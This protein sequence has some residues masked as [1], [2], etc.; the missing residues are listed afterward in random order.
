MKLKYIKIIKIL[1]MHFLS[2][3]QY[4]II[5]NEISFLLSSLQTNVIAVQV[6]Y[7]HRAQWDLVEEI[8][9]ISLYRDSLKEFW[10]I[11]VNVISQAATPP[12]N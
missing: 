1:P 5:Y 3:V 12:E 7:T 9:P 8:F 6:V 4:I 11:S 2:G 10:E